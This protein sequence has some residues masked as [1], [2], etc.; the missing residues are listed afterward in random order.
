MDEQK[1]LDPYK[2][3]LEIED[4]NW[5]LKAKKNN[6]KAYIWSVLLPPIGLYYF[7][8]YLFFPDG[9]SSSIRTGVICLVLTLISLFGNIWF[10]Q[11]FLNQSA[12]GDVKNLDTIKEL[13]TPENQKSLQQLLQ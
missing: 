12:G 5:N 3:I 2:A 7:V 13:I 11:L 6:Q 8:K 1:N 4:Q 9:E 10:I